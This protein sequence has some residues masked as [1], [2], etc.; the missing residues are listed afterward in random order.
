M[1]RSDC[2]AGG[3]NE[4]CLEE[5]YVSFEELGWDGWVLDPPGFK[6]NFCAG[7][8]HSPHSVPLPLT[9]P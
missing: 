5:A 2:A 6:A 3:Y 7:N 9:A 8:C 4:C 1:Q